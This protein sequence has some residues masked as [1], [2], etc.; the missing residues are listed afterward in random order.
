[1]KQPLVKTL[2]QCDVEMV[3]TGDKEV[4][5]EEIRRIQF[6]QPHGANLFQCYI[7]KVFPRFGDVC[8]MV[9]LSTLYVIY[10]TIVICHFFYGRVRK[11][12]INKIDQTK[13]K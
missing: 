13:I 2:P 10:L 6:S 11:I 8:H 3:D 7:Q 9:T 5:L 4:Q 1:M 12:K